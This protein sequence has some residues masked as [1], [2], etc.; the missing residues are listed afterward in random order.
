MPSDLRIDPSAVRELLDSETSVQVLDV[1]GSAAY[2]R[3]NE[4]VQAD[5]RVMARD[6]ASIAE[7]LDPDAW[8]LAYCT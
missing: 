4:R 7:Q 2:R 6:V 3:A 8:I 5:I 1:R